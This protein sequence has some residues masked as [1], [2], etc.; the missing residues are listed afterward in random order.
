MEGVSERIVASTVPRGRRTTLDAQCTMCCSADSELA[1]SGPTN[2][3]TDK[4]LHVSIRQHEEVQ[5]MRPNSSAYL[6]RRWQ[7]VSDT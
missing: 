7:Q 6:S 5:C 2:M 3:R 1:C 4:A